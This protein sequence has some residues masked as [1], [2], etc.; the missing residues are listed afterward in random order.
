MRWQHSGRAE[1]ATQRTQTD[2]DTFDEDVD[3]Q[4]DSKL[5]PRGQ[6]N[7]QQQRGLAPRMS[8]HSDTEI[9]PQQPRGS[10]G[11]TLMDRMS[12]TTC[13]SN[14][15]RTVTSNQQRPARR[16]APASTNKHHQDQQGCQHP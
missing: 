14:Y 6:S 4:H 9:Q 5:E 8:T 13:E 10:A 15:A 1:T 16:S 12:S 7:K 2:N 3:M 11:A